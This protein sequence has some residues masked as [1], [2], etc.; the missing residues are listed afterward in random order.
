MEANDGIELTEEQKKKR[1][2]RNI[3]IAMALGLFVVVFYIVT[4]VKLGPEAM[5]RPL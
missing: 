1:R 4:L 3:A 2:S 5:N